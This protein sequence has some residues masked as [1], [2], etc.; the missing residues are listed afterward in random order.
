MITSRGTRSAAAAV[1]IKPP[2]A[3]R[4]SAV[5]ACS[6]SSAPRTLIGR[7][8]TPS[9]G[10]K[11]CIAP[12][13]PGPAATAGVCRNATCFTPGA[14]SLS[15]SNHLA[16]MP[17]SNSMKPIALPPGRATVSTKTAPTGSPT[18]TNTIGTVRV[19]CSSGPVAA[20]V[21]ARMTSGAS[22]T[23]SPA[24][25]RM[26]SGSPAPQRMSMRAL[27][28]SIQPDCASARA[29][30]RTWV[31]SAGSS[32]ANDV[33]TPMCR[34]RSGCCAR[35]ASGHAAAAPPS[36]VINARRFIQPL[37][38]NHLVGEREQIV[39]DFDVQCPR[40]P[41]IDHELKFGRPQH[42]QVRRLLAFENP[43]GIAAGLSE[44]IISVDPIAHQPAGHR[45]FAELIHRG[46]GMARCKSNDPVATCVKERI[47]ADDE[48]ENLLTPDKIER[49]VDFA[50]AAGRQRAKL[51]AKRPRRRLSIRQLVHRS[52][53][54]SRIPQ[55]ANGCCLRH[56]LV[57]Q[58]QPLGL[59]QIGQDVDAGDVSARSV[60][61]LD[62]TGLDWVAADDEHDR[63]RGGRSFGRKR[64]RFATT[65]HE[66]V[67]LLADQIGSHCR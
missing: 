37:S 58:S 32:D 2:F 56:K 51:Q 22:A 62:E 18:C 36:S 4:A 61:A 17:Y 26:R 7:T 53:P 38:F 8:S 59:Q 6:I 24:Y 57:Q 46:H 42:R 9:D 41:Q 23:N 11:V 34:I 48:G 65:R 13:W 27:R 49:C 67:H 63:D 21:A 5:M 33:S 28:P 40:G 55:K 35:A 14:I 50:G 29:N 60:E 30:A 15:S 47:G 20:L 31:C 52:R 10:A 3:G 39:R 25:L 54:K 44:G 1:T 19:A 43:S 66:Y 16:P 12:N 64:R 45:M